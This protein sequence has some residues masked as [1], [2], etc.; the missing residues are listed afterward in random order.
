MFVFNNN[1][2]G[3]TT[4]PAMR[5]T[6]GALADRAAAFGMAAA[7]VDGT[8]VLDVHDEAR[9]SMDGARMATNRAILASA[10]P[11]HGHVEGDT[12]RYRAG[13]ESAE[14]AARWTPCRSSATR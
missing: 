7:A 8:D 2:Y 13:D 3:D 5:S 11:F 9:G 1:G 6:R 4:D 10:V 14:S 12:S